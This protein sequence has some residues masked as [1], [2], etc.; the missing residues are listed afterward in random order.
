MTT[1]KAKSALTVCLFSSHSLVLGQLEKLLHAPNL[2]LAAHKLPTQTDPMFEIT[3]AH[4]YVIDTGSAGADACHFVSSII[5]QSTDA[6]ILAIGDC[7]TEAEAFPLLRLGVKGLLKYEEAEGQLLRAVQAVSAGGF[8]VPRQLLSR[9]V[10]ILLQ[11]Q[12]K[13]GRDSSTQISGREQ[14]VLN[15]LL[16]N[17]SNK[18]IANKLFISERTVKF[19]VSN[20]LSKFRVQRRADLI[21]LWFQRSQQ[22][23]EQPH[24]IPGRLM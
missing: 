15:A 7:F 4:L 12:P 24:G 16:Q 19:H 14:E 22:T 11:E 1:T 8:W 20:L 21:V 13:G 10:D 9:F 23:S 2:R 6:Q 3:P 18:E 17:L 5:K